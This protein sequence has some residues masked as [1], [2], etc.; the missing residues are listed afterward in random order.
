MEPNFQAVFCKLSL[1][2]GDWL[3]NH[4]GG[5]LAIQKLL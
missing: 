2:V 3:F 4:H 1:V 5:L